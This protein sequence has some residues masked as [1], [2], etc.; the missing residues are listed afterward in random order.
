MHQTNHEIIRICNKE[1]SIIITCINWIILAIRKHICA[2][3]RIARIAIYIRI[4]KS[5]GIGVV[6]AAL[7]VVKP[8]VC[9]I[10]IAS[11]A[12]GVY[13]CN[14]VGACNYCAAVVFNRRKRTLMVVCI[15]CR[16]T[17]V[18]IHEHGNIALQVLDI[19]VSCA[20]VEHGADTSVLVALSPPNWVWGG[21]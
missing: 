7:E 15:S 21:T 1:T 2:Q 11:V 20:A 6:V 19:V 5:A 3:D 18:F 17:A 8:G 13:I 10:D 14:V 16:N 12:Q 9:V 4:N